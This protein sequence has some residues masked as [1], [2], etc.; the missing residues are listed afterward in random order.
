MAKTRAEFPAQVLRDARGHGRRA[1]CA[2][3]GALGF[4]P[5]DIAAYPCTNG[6]QRG[7]RHFDATNLMNHKARDDDMTCFSCRADARRAAEIEERR[8]RAIK[9]ALRERGSWR[10][11]CRCPI[12][13]ERCQLFPRQAGERRWPGK[14]KGVAEDDLAF[15]DSLD[16]KRRRRR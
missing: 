8:E 15:L 5:K 7:H 16:Q 4:S 12:H 1:V 13:Q 14:N 10:C 2:A 6:C 3:C 9:K 11:T